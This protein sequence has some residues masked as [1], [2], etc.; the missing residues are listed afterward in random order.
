VVSKF[1][2]LVCAILLVSG[3]SSSVPKNN[4]ENAETSIQT[5]STLFRANEWWG[6]KKK[7]RTLRP[8]ADGGTKIVN[9]EEA[10]KHSMPWMVSLQSA[11]GGYYF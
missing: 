8:V 2:H 1:S 5:S 6:A 9:G 11:S 7:T 3:A 10:T 4:Q